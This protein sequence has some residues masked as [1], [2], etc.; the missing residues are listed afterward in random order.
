MIEKGMAFY[1]AGVTELRLVTK[2]KLMEQLSCHASSKESMYTAI[3][4][5]QQN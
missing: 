1:S 5:K 2:R 4:I 3:K